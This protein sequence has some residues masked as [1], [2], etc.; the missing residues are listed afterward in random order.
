M[1]PVRQVVRGSVVI[2][3]FYP[4]I[5][6]TSFE[7]RMDGLQ[8]NK[9]AGQALGGY[10]VIALSYQWR[11]AASITISKTDEDERLHTVSGSP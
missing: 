8:Y 7:A 6:D 2:R 4:S 1:I 5:E 11:P 10:P 9:A 3:S